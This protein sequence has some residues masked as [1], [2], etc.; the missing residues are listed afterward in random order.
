MMRGMKKRAAEQKALIQGIWSDSYLF[1]VRYRDDEDAARWACV[2]EDFV[3]LLQKYDNADP[4]GKVMLAVLASLED[5][6]KADSLTWKDSWQFYLKYHGR[7]TEPGMWMEATEDFG[8]IMK[9]H[10]GS[11]IC[12]RL[13]LA[14]FS[15]LEEETCYVPVHESNKR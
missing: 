8:R 3:D 10:R 14:A 4:C 12:A 5:G 13:M 1:Y 7:P 6:E 15:T 9:E 11:A 2:H